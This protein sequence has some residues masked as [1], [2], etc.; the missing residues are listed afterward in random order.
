MAGVFLAARGLAFHTGPNLAVVGLGRI[1]SWLTDRALAQELTGQSGDSMPGS[2]VTMNDSFHSAHPTAQP[3][4]HRGNFMQSYTGKKFYSLDPRPEDID[5]VDI[6]HALSMQCRYNGHYRRFYSVAEHCVL[7]SKLFTAEYALWALLH[8]ETEAYVGDMVRPLKAH[9]PDYCAAEDR[10]MI[11][12]AERFGLESAVMPPEVVAADTASCS[13]IAALCSA[14]RQGTGALTA[15]RSVLRST[16]G[17]RR[18]LG[19]SICSVSSNSPSTAM[20]RRLTCSSMTP[21]PGLVRSNS[22]DE[23]EGPVKTDHEQYRVKPRVS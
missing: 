20:P 22:R 4:W 10:V 11:A 2:D 17:R 9:L 1:A 16:D 21:A 23:P 18:P 19:M 15:N 7:L 12:I 3:S 6:A 8:D 14:S 13:T 5:I